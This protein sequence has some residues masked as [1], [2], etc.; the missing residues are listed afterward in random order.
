[1]QIFQGH[2]ENKVNQL[3]KEYGLNMLTPPKKR[4]ELL[5]AL[6]CLFAGFNFLL[7]LGSLA[8][9]VSYIIE[10]RQSTDVKLDN[11]SNASI[12]TTFRNKDGRLYHKSFS[13][14]IWVSFLRLSSWSL[15][16]SPT[17]KSIKALK[18][19]KVLQDWH[20]PLQWYDYNN[21]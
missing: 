7:W 14:F 10:R 2:S 15:D 8:S 21:S 16:F 17:I 1:M 20:H 13:S 11:V 6:K 9:V 4:S 18:L 3:I 19:W 12:S 5:A